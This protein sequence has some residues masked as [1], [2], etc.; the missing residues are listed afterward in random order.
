MATQEPFSIGL[1]MAGAVSAGA[2][3]AGV[4]DYLIE[5][6]ED[7]Q[8]RKDNGH[9]NVPSHN[10]EIPVIGGASA[11]G[12][13]AIVTAAAIHDPII[14]VTAAPVNLLDKIENNNLYHSWV[15]LLGEDMLS[16]ILDI[17]DIQKNGL[18]SALNADFID[19]IAER[20]VKVNGVSP[21][22]RKYF[23]E[24]LKLFVTLSNLQGMDYCVAFKSLHLENNNRD[25]HLITVHNDYACFQLDEQY[26]NDGW[27]P[28]NLSKG[29]NTK[30]AAQAA[31][32][33]GAFPGGL[34]ARILEREG[35]YLNE[36]KWFDDITKKAGRPFRLNETINTTNIDG[37]MINNEPFEK[38]QEILN[39][40]TNQ[41]DP[42]EY[43]DYNKFKGTVLMIDPF[44]SEIDAEKLKNKYDRNKQNSKLIPSI[45]QTL[46]A[47]IGQAR[48]K[49]EI[50]IDAWESNNAA[51]FIIAPVRYQEEKA[52]DG[53]LALACGALDGF[54]GFLNKEFRIHD[55]FLGRAN[56]EKFLRD[57]FTIPEDSTNPIFQ[58][59]YDNISKE[60]LKRFQA[61]D[62]GLQIIP[63]F[64]P[65]KEKPY[66]PKF[67]NGLQWPSVSEELI[68]SYKKKIA[69]RV[70]EILMNIT[71]L[72][73][74][75][76]F[77]L[78]LGSKV[79]LNKKL[80]NVIIKSIINSLKKQKQ[81][82]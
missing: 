52:I 2:Y 54:G 38:V 47:L 20:A 6:L 49:P 24:N 55:Y 36:N 12:M 31:M 73:G 4:M 69:L 57:H 37:G 65:R 26:K 17:S 82:K 56:C 30:I 22:K 48:F 80:T 43:K 25:R 15:D 75:E 79:I 32:A 40:I 67:S 5:A 9:A 14:P 7:W 62:G 76:K 53:S 3:T 46:G 44:P 13:T 11:G 71:E 42:K 19:K 8:N 39:D 34:K 64:T 59:G 41:S 10:V 63:I 78:W 58:K 27:I 23:K 1:C 29:I 61:I 18:E 21:V 68:W 33:T 51:Q 50:F 81:L 70:H 16:I 45:R 28:L 74:I 66:M 77:L 60:E 35:K 72:S